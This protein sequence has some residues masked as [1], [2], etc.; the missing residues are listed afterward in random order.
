ML[1]PNIMFIAGVND[2]FG[3][4]ISIFTYNLPTKPLLRNRAAAR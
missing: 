2:K 3:K 4:I 1:I